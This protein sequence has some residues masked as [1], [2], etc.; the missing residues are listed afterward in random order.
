[1]TSSHVDSRGRQP[2]DGARGFPPLQNKSQTARPKGFPQLEVLT[3][4]I[5]YAL[6]STAVAALL[7][8]A[9]TCAVPAAGQTTVKS[10][11][12]VKGQEQN[13]L[14]GLGFVVGLKG[15][16]DGGNFLPTIRALEKTL[17]VMGEPLGK[18]GLAELKDAKNVALVM[19]TA[20]VPAGGARQGD[21]LD[22]VVS[23]MGAAKSLAGGRLFLTPLVGPH[24]KDPRV[25]AL[26]GG[27]VT[28][29]DPDF[30]T[31]GRIHGGCR[32]EADFYN[33]FSKDGRIN[34]VLDKNH[35][36]FHVAQEVADL[37]NNQLSFQAS[38]D[39][40]AKALDQTNVVVRIPGQYREDPV[41]F[42]SQVL[43]LPLYQVRTVPR[44]VIHERT[45][46]IVIG[47]DVEI[48]PA[49]VTHRNVVVETGGSAAGEPFVPLQAGQATPAKLKSLVEAL[50]AVRVPN[51]DVI[52]IIKALARDGKLH[53]ELIV[54]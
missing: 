52:D 42:V 4:M 12:R 48:G 38:G 44:V 54:E 17:R 45:G 7:M 11:C 30:P 24:P 2:A 40:L 1:M 37:V 25:Y 53:A 9:T 14:H 23:S 35:A 46:A 49:V 51:E 41:M 32:L 39:V 34:L 15:T 36:D 13:T 16:G 29:E 43:E 5:R 20:T 47:G 33:A 3:S 26:A 21:E 19:V 27:S 31:T 10:I 28:I 50:N 8:A 6:N 22:C 18:Q